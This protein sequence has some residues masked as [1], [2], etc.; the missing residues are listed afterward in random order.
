M[1]TL[2]NEPDTDFHL[3]LN[4]QSFHIPYELLTRN[5]KL[6]NELIERESSLLN[7]KFHELNSLLS[8]NAISHDKIAITKLNSIIK[9]IDLFEAKLN[10]KITR[11]SEL[12][13]R[14]KL[15]I[16][17]FQD[18]QT[19]K[20]NHDTN[21]LIDWYQKYSNLLIG[22][23]LTRFPIIEKSGKRFLT[24]Q[25]LQNLLDFDILEKANYISNAL[26]NSH[27]LQPLIAWIDENNNYLNK[28]KS[29]LE[30]KARFQEYLELLKLNDHK[31]AIRSL[32]RNLLPFMNTNFDD[33]KIACGLLVFME[34]CS[35]DTPNTIITNHDNIDTREKAYEYFFHK[36]LDL[37]MN[38]DINKMKSLSNSENLDRY[39][40]LLDDH[41]WTILKDTFLDEYYSLY[42]ISKND[43][44]LIYISLGIPT[45]K[46]K[47]CLQSDNS[48]PSE[49]NILQ[50]HNKNYLKNSCPVCNDSFAPIAE[51]LPFAHHTESKLFE[52]PVM[53]PNGNVYDSNKLKEMSHLLI[54]EKIANLK[55]NEIFD[56]ISKTVFKESDFVT[57]YPT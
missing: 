24:E 9:S 21:K 40:E 48:I 17:F 31:N 6:L 20:D 27:D 54:V 23:Y 12:L 2:I 36:R 3:Q 43:P 49:Y 44:L 10:D 53:L 56:P 33:L 29:I 39:R 14:I 46:T 16:N 38:T 45:L 1:A 7:K 5:F 8:K 15:R 26:V 25:N 28:R 42:G 30:F 57:M 50:K 18:L 47:A 13:N 55:D 52:N 4:E 22:E 51:N 35:N 11:E 37:S 34:N 19:F 32:Q 41:R